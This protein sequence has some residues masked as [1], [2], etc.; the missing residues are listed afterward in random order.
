MDFQCPNGHEN[1]FT[2]DYWRRHRECPI[3]K[4]NRYYRMND[5][6]PK[7]KGFRILAFDQASGTSGWAVY[8]DQE[9]IKYGAW[10]SDGNHS[11]EKIMKTKN[12]VANMI[13]MWKPDLVIFEDIQLQKTEHGEEQVL[14]F[15]KLAHLQGVLKN[16]CY[17]NGY[18]F[19]IVPPATW[20][21]HSQVKGTNRTDKKKSAQLIVKKLYDMNVTQDEADAIL[22]GRWAAHDRKQNIMIQ[23]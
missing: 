9:L 1:Y 16:Y 5:S 15:K 20:R 13:Q 8:D 12:W 6:A 17:E 10:T 3:C 11:T 2:F 19:K 21:A 14:T 18:I 4:S 23:F 22:I 7:S